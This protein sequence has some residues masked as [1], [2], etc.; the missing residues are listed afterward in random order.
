MVIE[1]LENSGFITA[2]GA[3]DRGI[4]VMALPGSPLDPCSQG[5]NG[6]IRD[7]A[8]LVQNIDDILSVL[9]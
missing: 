7:G 9:S 3:A 8:T 1:S 2:R 4:E 5:T 6:L